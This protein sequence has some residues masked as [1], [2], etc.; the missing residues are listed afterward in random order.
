MNRDDM[1]HD[2]EFF[3]AVQSLE[4]RESLTFLFPLLCELCFT[5]THPSHGF[6]VRETRAYSTKEVEENLHLKFP[7]PTILFFLANSFFLFV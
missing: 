2:T 4:E 7:Y 1:E 3:F 6:S 5:S